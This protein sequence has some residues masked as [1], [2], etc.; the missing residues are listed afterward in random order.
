MDLISKHL[1]ENAVKSWI[2]LA[3]KLSVAS[4]ITSNSLKQSIALSVV[5]LMSIA[6]HCMS[7]FRAFI[8]ATAESHFFVF[9]PAESCIICL[10]S[11]MVEAL[12]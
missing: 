5:N 12:E 10:I 9:T 1:Y 11:I 6:V 4:T 2:Y 3:S 7:G 8:R